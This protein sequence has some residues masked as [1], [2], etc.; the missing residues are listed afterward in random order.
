MTLG[1]KSNDK[2]IMITIMMV[3]I[4]IMVMI[5]ITTMIIEVKTIEIAK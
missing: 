2:N 3:V 5:T 1:N 4:V